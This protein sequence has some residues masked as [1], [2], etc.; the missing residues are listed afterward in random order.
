MGIEQKKS[1]ETH[2]CS[3]VRGWV[4]HHA[5][6]LVRMARF[7]EMVLPTMPSTDEGEFPGDPEPM[8]LA[9]QAA[10]AFEVFAA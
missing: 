3:V 2:A 9:S 5:E 10:L 4:M 8:V 6:Q 7:T 1:K